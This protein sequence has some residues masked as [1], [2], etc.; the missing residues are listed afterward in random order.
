[1]FADA[2]ET[3]P[4]PGATLEKRNGKKQSEVLDAAWGR[5]EALLAAV[6]PAWARLS[7]ERAGVR[8]IR[9][10]SL[11]PIYRKCLRNAMR[12]LTVES[13]IPAPWSAASRR[14]LPN[15]SP[16]VPATALWGPVMSWC[17]LQTLAM[18]IDEDHLER[19]ALDLF[20][21]LR[22][23]EPLAQ[24]F[25]ALGMEGERGWRAV[26][27]LKILL[28]IEAGVGAEVPAQLKAATPAAARLDEA[29]KALVS[30]AVSEAPAP[31][32]AQ[33][34]PVHADGETSPKSGIP[35]PLWKDP[36]VRWLTGFNE[37]EGH[38]Y[39]IREPYE[40]L[41]WWLSL[42]SLLKLA[43]MNVPT[44]NA[45]SPIAARIKEALAAVEKAGYRIDAMLQPEAAERD[46]PAQPAPA[47]VKPVA[48]GVES[49]PAPAKPVHPVDGPPEDY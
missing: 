7:G 36:D 35:A 5:C 47:A 46:A 18:A 24:A 26:A 22:L 41:L 30:E 2:V 12:L 23:R 32:P 21:R 14:V 45:A 9:P 15:S 13:L 42:P 4:V 48:V 39:V 6:L 34:K 20:D 28:M 11:F 16:D 33:E 1:M 8:P 31:S 44:R 37:A 29:A 40:E 10:E 38:T 43:N 19:T 17:L 27:R 49:E 3:P 25:Q